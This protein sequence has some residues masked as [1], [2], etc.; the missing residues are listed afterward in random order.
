MDNKKNIKLFFIKLISITFSI[1]L[2]INVIYNLFLADKM[3][4]INNIIS[5]D[6]SKFRTELKT[7]IRNEIINGLKKDHMI[8]EEDKLLLYKLY[9]K[10]KDEIDDLE[11][12]N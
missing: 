11:E 7:K 12:M 3:E 9:I 6:K 10:I 5:L 2:I 1:I 8:N 4:V